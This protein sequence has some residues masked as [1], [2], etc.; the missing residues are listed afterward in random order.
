MNAKTPLAVG[1][2][3]ASLVLGIAGSAQAGQPV[4]EQGDSAG[5]VKLLDNPSGLTL[6][7]KQSIDITR[8][9]VTK[10]ARAVRF[11]WTLAAVTSSTSFDQ[12]LSVI[13]RGGGDEAWF[14][15]LN[16]L[17]ED[18]RFTEAVYSPTVDGDDSVYCRPKATVQRTTV[19]VDV[20]LKCIPTEAGVMRVTSATGDY[21]DD[22]VEFSRDK[23]RVEGRP[24]LR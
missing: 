19:R 14:M 18:P 7:E 12:L 11:S 1:L 3:V 20:P 22:D 24:D 15:L 13:F 23:L 4:V 17:P 16:V 8:F 10:R 9:S 5:D 6:A 21:S 2:A